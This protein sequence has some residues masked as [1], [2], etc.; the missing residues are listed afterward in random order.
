MMT[1][2]RKTKDPAQDPPLL[3]GDESTGG[4]VSCPRCGRPVADG[5][6][7]CGGCGMRIL[8]GVAAPRAFLFLTTGAVLGL[9]VGGLAVGSIMGANR[10]SG[11]GTTAVLPP[12][13]SPSASPSATSATSPLPSVAKQA[14]DPLAA[15]AL[16][17]VA[18]TNLQLI[19]SLETLKQELK[20]RSLDTGAMSATLRSMSAAATY[21][22]TVVGYL[23]AWPA[24]APLQG[25]VGR[26]YTQVVAV[27]ASGLGAQLASQTA[28]RAAGDQI[29][30]ILAALPA[31]EDAADVLG[32]SGGV[33][34]PG[35]VNPA[36]SPAA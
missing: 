12:G 20:Q 23:S 10:T 26:L 1:R 11:G 14:V 21:G 34:L 17:Q 25:Q 35:A 30:S 6:V 8:M 24:A 16:R 31:I 2:A 19:S 36:P 4:Y 22:G 29:V 18:S 15:S 27:A 5:L 32:Q 7:R 28:Y 9:L 13:Q 33:D 3:I